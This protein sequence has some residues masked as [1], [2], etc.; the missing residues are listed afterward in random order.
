MSATHKA[1]CEAIG[2]VLYPY[3][4]KGRF[5]LFLRDATQRFLLALAAEGY[6]VTPTA[7][8]VAG[9]N[10]VESSSGANRAPSGDS[11]DPPNEGGALGRLTGSVIAS[12]KNRES[13]GS[14]ERCPVCLAP[15]RDGG[16]E[17]CWG[18][19]LNHGRVARGV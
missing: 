13:E 2:N 5:E 10:R 12:Q 16:R 1:V 6:S 11:A 18:C 7:S 3:V 17:P 9:V 15:I 19:T 8:L 14:N 4:S